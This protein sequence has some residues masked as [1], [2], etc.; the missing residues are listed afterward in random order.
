[1]SDLFDR[2]SAAGHPAI[3]LPRL[4]TGSATVCLVSAG[5]RETQFGSAAL[6]FARF[7]M[8]PVI[9]VVYEHVWRLDAGNWAGQYEAERCR[10]FV[11]AVA[12]S[13]GWAEDEI[14]NPALETAARWIFAPQCGAPL[15]QRAAGCVLAY[16]GTSRETKKP[17]VTYIEYTWSPIRN[18][19]L[20]AAYRRAAVLPDEVEAEFEATEH[21]AVRRAEAG[22][23][24]AEGWM[25]LAAELRESLRG[26]A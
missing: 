11:G 5:R 25:R 14:D 24:E 3:P 26:G 6:L 4:P 9:A 20:D 16:T 17:G 2:L 23:P 13:M 18:I 7:V 21:E 10:R 12:E 15:N 1:M 8:W 19:A 22:D